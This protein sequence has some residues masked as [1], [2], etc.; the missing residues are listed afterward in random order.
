MYLFGCCHLVVFAHSI[1]C[2]SI[3][4]AAFI[5]PDPVGFQ[6]EF[7]DTFPFSDSLAPSLGGGGDGPLDVVPIRSSESIALN[8]GLYIYPGLHCT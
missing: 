3:Y 4:A 8:A 7:P 2:Y 5:K 1:S 6:S